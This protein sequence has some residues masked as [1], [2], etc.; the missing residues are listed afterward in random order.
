MSENLFNEYGRLVPESLTNAVYEQSRRYFLCD[1]PS[2]D[3]DDIYSRTCNILGPADDLTADDFRGRIEKILSS[4]E[5][6]PATKGITAGVHIP[7]LIPRMDIDDL[8][9]ALEEHYLPAVERAFLQ[10]LPEAE[11]SNETNGLAGKLSVRD[12]SRHGQLLEK[13]AKQSVVGVYFPAMTE[14]SVPAA[15]EQIQRMPEN[16][17]L[18]GGIDLCAALIAAPDALIR[19]DGYP[20][21]FWLTAIQGESE[22]ICY[23]FEAYGYNLKLYRRAHLG[24]TSEYWWQG[25]TV[26]G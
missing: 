15:V 7:L 20:P 10:R 11:F 1:A 24:Q 3:L 8:G 9:S 25:I 2:T 18:T 16:C 5:S 17:L 26:L 12:G 6:D 19:K 21:T 22:N 4:L 23:H 13:L 14:Y